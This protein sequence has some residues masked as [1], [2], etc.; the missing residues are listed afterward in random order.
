MTLH[1]H[2]CRLFK[3]GIVSFYKTASPKNPAARQAGSGWI[4]KFLAC[5]TVHRKEMLCYKINES[6]QEVDNN[7]LI[8]NSWHVHMGLEGDETSTSRA[9]G[10]HNT[11]FLLIYRF[12]LK[13]HGSGF[14]CA[15]FKRTST[16][17][18]SDVLSKRRDKKY[19]NGWNSSK[20]PPKYFI[21]HSHVMDW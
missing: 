6:F 16:F 18:C 15:Q 1:E 14:K 5:G 8:T 2:T 11:V 10:K 13:V 4:A 7:E 9:R 17:T 12:T 3:I 19:P 20:A 21:C